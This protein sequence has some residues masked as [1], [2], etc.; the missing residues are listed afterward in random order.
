MRKCSSSR[1]TPNFSGSR[2]RPVEP[3]KEPSRPCGRDPRRPA[4]PGERSQAHRSRPSSPLGASALAWFCRVTRESA[5]RMAV[6][7]ASRVVSNVTFL[8][9]MPPGFVRIRYFGYAIRLFRDSRGL[10]SAMRRRF[11]PYVWHELTRHVRS[12]I[13][14]QVR[15]ATV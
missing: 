5:G 9:V 10:P 14:S 2:L 15:E 11:M 3:G 1:F 12:G 4:R 6:M 7:A 8:H 13:N